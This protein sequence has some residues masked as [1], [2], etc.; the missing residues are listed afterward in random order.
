MSYATLCN[1]ISD[2]FIEHLGSSN[3]NVSDFLSRPS[4]SYTEYRKH[5]QQARSRGRKRASSGLP[6]TTAA[7]AAVELNV[8]VRS[9]RDT[10]GRL[11]ARCE[12]G[13]APSDSSRSVNRCSNQSGLVQGTQ[14]LNKQ[15]TV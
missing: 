11:R 5:L 2:I 10:P 12:R 6:P 13:R 4:K 9:L 15:P 14:I 1:F 3:Y 8:T 7:A